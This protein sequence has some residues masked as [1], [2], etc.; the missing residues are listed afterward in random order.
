M[1]GAHEVVD[2]D[3]RLLGEKAQCLA[4]DDKDV[5]PERALDAEAVGGE[6]AVGRRVGAELKERAIGGAHAGGSGR[7]R[8]DAPN[9]H[10][11]DKPGHDARALS[12][13]DIVGRAGRSKR[14][15]GG[16]I[17]PLRAP[18][19]ACRRGRARPDAADGRVSDASP[20]PPC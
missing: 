7:L 15:L 16:T 9:R 19:R 20:P 18:A 13:A 2:V 10:G 4:L 17:V 12:A 14:R 5:A 8:D 6:L 3:H 11:R 1:A